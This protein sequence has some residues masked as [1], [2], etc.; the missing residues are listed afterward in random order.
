MLFE[1]KNIAA[2]KAKNK[3]PTTRPAEMIFYNKLYVNK[4][5]S[6]YEEWMISDYSTVTSF[7]SLTHMVLNTHNFCAEFLAEDS[8]KIGD[9][10]PYKKQQQL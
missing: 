1:K 7:L 8:E 5:S 6:M 4:I 10:S 2:F 3:P 9:I